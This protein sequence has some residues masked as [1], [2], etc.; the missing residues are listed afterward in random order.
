[1]VE[2]LDGVLTA[3]QTSALNRTLRADPA[4][5]LALAELVL[6]EIQL[7][8]LGRHARTPLDA[9][10]APCAGSEAVPR[11]VRPLEVQARAAGPDRRGP[12]RKAI[13][14]S[15]ALAASLVALVAIRTFV[16][17]PVGPAVLRP[18]GDG[19][20]LERGA[21]TKF[22]KTPT[23]LAPGD[24]VRAQGFCRIEFGR[25]QARLELDPETALTFARLSPAAE[26]RLQSG[27]LYGSVRPRAT[28]AGFVFLTAHGRAVVKGTEF[29]L[30]VAPSQ[31]SLAVYGGKVQL[32]AAGGERVQVTAGR[33]ARTGP[34][35]ALVSAPI[36]GADR[37]IVLELWRNV[38]P[39]APGDPIEFAPAD[40][41]PAQTLELDRLQTAPQALGDRC[42]VRI[43]GYLHP[44]R[45]GAYGFWVAAD[46]RGEVWLSPS[47]DPRAK[48]RVCHTPEYTAPLQWDRRPEQRSEPQVLVAGRRY[49]FEV[50]LSEG[51]G[52]DHLS[53]A[54]QGP[55][56]PAPIVIDRDHVS[57]WDPSK[58]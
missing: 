17:G 10:C 40:A 9:A 31:T 29:K 30:A 16:T 11:S 2:Y 21:A 45:T 42:L 52:G 43:R 58:D 46:D 19:A 27:V 15:V 7:A 28:R 57:P 37:R 41:P 6:Q 38:N 22:V 20:W 51:G 54:W 39:A 34:G 36:P 48:R 23:E 12:S 49:Y 1:M 8:A 3:D 14:W 55:R 13:G 25:D 32:T 50:W 35:L 4:A 56:Q 44:D 26:L 47:E 33:Q 5:Q 24:T 53:V 18:L